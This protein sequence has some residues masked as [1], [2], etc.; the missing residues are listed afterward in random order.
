[1]PT[2]RLLADDLTGALDTAAEF[3]K[4]TGPV[5]VFWQH[6]QAR[7]LP[8][9]AALDLGTREADRDTARA[10]TLAALPTL[11]GA[12]I[13][14]KKIDSLMRGQTL[15]ELAACADSGGWARCVLAPAFP[16]QGR[17]TRQGQQFALIDGAWRPVGPDLVAALHALGVSA[18]AGLGETGVCVCDAESD[19]DL[20][21]LVAQVGGIGA[22]VLW[23]GTGGLARALAGGGFD[24]P[25]D[26]PP[27]I[28]GLFGSDHAAT[29]EQ[30]AAC[31]KHWVALPDGSGASAAKLRAALERHGLVLAT[32][33]LPPGLGR[34]E[35]AERIDRAFR[36][37]LRHLPAPGT[38]VVA[39]GETLR[40]LCLGLG[41]ERLE[42][43][44]RLM[45]GVP[46]SILRGGPWHGVT[47]VS[48]SGAFGHPSLLRDLLRPPDLEG[49][50]A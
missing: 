22:P 15:A 34:G 47:I 9:S 7:A 28:L 35:A 18:Q 17:I 43:Q 8:A 36:A 33:A 19:A 13:A 23:C 25:P 2:L 30:L 37:L 48:K 5:P 41:A 11:A 27:P 21:A 29:A 46:V 49:I 50:S 16:F 26:L 1:M 14:F 31:G 4:L 40:G 38:L 32:N 45:P 12:D 39:G 20:A 10:I 6:T 24:Q 3:V 44:G 42:V